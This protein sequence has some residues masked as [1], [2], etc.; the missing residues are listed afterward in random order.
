[1][2]RLV[3]TLIVLGA[4]SGRGP[5]RVGAQPSWRGGMHTSQAAGPV[6]FAPASEPAIRYNEPP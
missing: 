3:V 5:Q 6:T 4:C 1:M 2:R